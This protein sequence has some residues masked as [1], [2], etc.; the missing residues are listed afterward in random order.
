MPLVEIGLK[1]MF[2]KK[3]TKIDEIFNVDLTLC[4][5]CTEVSIDGKDFVNFCG[6][7]GLLRKGKHPRLDPT[8]LLLSCLSL[9]I[10]GQ[11]QSNAVLY[12]IIF[13]N[14]IN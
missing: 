10:E 14:L 3:A 9:N 5:K 13:I 4:S 8:G 7:C 6:G 2:S 1:F 12:H 11:N